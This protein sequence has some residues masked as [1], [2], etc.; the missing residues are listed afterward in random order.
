[1]A[2]RLRLYGL[3]AVVTNAAGGI[4]EAIARTLV[5]H[6]ATVL[7]IDTINS[8]VEQHFASVKGVDGFAA[9][10]SEAARMPALVEQDNRVGGDDEA[11]TF[12]TAGSRSS[13]HCKRG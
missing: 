11:G 9:N 3:K 8:G 4:G 6:G 5:K 12:R 1:M 7:A 2:D 10:S 13:A